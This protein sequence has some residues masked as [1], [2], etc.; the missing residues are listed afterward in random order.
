[1]T[2]KRAWTGLVCVC[3]VLLLFD[4][5]LAQERT[6]RRQPGWQGPPIGAVVEDFE[7][8]L[9]DGGTFKLSDQR[10]RILAIEMGACT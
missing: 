4:S 2:W 6:R 10:G 9:V 3:L 7:L 5:V 8:P 1:M